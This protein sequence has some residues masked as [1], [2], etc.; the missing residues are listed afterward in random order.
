VICGVAA[1]V[2]R[3][4]PGFVLQVSVNDEPRCANQNDCRVGA[5]PLWRDRP[6]RLCSYPLMKSGADRTIRLRG[7]RRLGYAEWGEPEGEPVFFCHGWLRT[8][9]R[10]ACTA[11]G[12]PVFSPHDL[13][14]RRIS[15]CTWPACP[16]PPSAKA[17]VSGT[18]R[19][20][21]RYVRF[22]HG[23]LTGSGVAR[24]RPERSVRGARGDGPRPCPAHR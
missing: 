24:R 3:S 14:H 21:S 8:A 10:R 19:S 7:G 13:R 17:S 12:V 16:G 18:S 22:L 5:D 23:P 1:A 4:L 11:A 20:P 9:I 15:L 2:L 6:A